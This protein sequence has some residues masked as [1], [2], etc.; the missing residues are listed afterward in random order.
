M[1]L[2]LVLQPTSPALMQSAVQTL[3]Y[4]VH[5]AGI[6]YVKGSNACVLPVC[7]FAIGADNQPTGPQLAPGGLPDLVP[8]A[9]PMSIL[10]SQKEPGIAIAYRYVTD[11][12]FEAGGAGT[13][14]SPLL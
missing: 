13:V 8:V 6:H 9:N 5:V 4:Y 7:Y 3:N 14:I 1:A 12:L 2:K 10:A 11:A